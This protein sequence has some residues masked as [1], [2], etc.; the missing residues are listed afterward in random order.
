[1]PPFKEKQETACFKICASAL[2]CEAQ[3]NL[4]NRQIYYNI[5]FYFISPAWRKCEFKNWFSFHIF[6]I[7]KKK[8]KIKKKIGKKNWGNFFLLKCNFGAP[9]R[10]KPSKGP[11]SGPYEIFL[12]FRWRYP[13][14]M[15]TDQI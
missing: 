10:V 14:S 3:F 4:T 15:G 11:N 2:E 1:M 7:I 9:K 8:L 6:W 13:E 12:F 5:L